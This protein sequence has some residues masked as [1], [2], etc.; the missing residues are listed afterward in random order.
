MCTSTRVSGSLRPSYL[1]YF[2]WTT[3]ESQIRDEGWMVVRV[4]NYLDCR[5]TPTS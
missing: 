5:V 4:E 2:D 3:V 1:R